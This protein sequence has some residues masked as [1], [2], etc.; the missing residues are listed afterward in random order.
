M[1][2]ERDQLLRL[3]EPQRRALEAARD[4]SL[5]WARPVL[6]GGGYYIRQQDW[7]T[8]GV[9]PQTAQ[10]LINRGLIVRPQARMGDWSSMPVQITA[11]GRSAL[12]A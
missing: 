2:P 7:R 9:R 3:S 1:S 5:M 10:A 4:G 12:D 11:A 8:S 6:S